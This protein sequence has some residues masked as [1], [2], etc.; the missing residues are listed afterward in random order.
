MNNE[1]ALVADNKNSSTSS[2]PIQLYSGLYPG[3]WSP[4]ELTFPSPASD[5]GV[6][7]L[8]STKS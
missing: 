5:V 6:T 3:N 4:R 7:K 2:I 1:D 8:A